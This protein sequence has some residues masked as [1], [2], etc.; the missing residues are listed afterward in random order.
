MT[1]APVTRHDL[2]PFWDGEPITWHGWPPEES[3]TTLIHHVPADRMACEQCGT[4]DE[5]LTNWGSR[6]PTPDGPSWPVRDIWAARCRHCGHDQVHDE[7]T[8]ETWD[9]E[10]DDY[11]DTGSTETDT[12]F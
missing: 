3:R 5:R 6:P 10:P 9:L 8:N 4:V 1:S 12:L 11:T 2:P 7:R